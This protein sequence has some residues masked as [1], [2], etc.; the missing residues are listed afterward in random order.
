[1]A[2]KPKTNGAAKD[3]PGITTSAGHNSQTITDEYHEERA[4]KI[5]EIVGDIVAAKQKQNDGQTAV[6][7][8]YKRL[9][10]E[11]ALEGPAAK[12][13]I[14]LSQMEETKRAIYFRDFALVLQVLGV[15]I[16]SSFTDVLADAERSNNDGGDLEGFDEDASLA[17]AE[18]GDYEVADELLTADQL[19]KIG[20]DGAQAY[21]DGKSEADCSFPDGTDAHAAWRKGFMD[22][23]GK[24]GPPAAA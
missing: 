24:D 18:N 7:R 3:K 13:A 5:R 9:E 1:M 11:C 20:E 4:A 21:E 14:G 23:Y 15:P 8:H 10:K 6:A 2:K 12:Q 16:Q 19:K 17:A 22:A